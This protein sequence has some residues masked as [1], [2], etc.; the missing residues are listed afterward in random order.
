[1]KRRIKKELIYYDYE[2]WGLDTNSSNWPE[3]VHNK[4]VEF[5]NN[6]NVVLYKEYLIH[7]DWTVPLKKKYEKI[8]KEEEI[9]EL[10]EEI[11]D[12]II[13]I[14]KLMKGE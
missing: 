5:P 3:K 12:I 2:K 6:S 1:M 14:R 7:I 11:K 9:D 10:L 8:E 4:I 13:D